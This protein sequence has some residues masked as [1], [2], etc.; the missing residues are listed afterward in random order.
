MPMSGLEIGNKKMK[1]HFKV[2]KEKKGGYWADCIELEGCRTQ[3]ATLKTLTKN[4]SEALNLY[5]SE[6]PESQHVFARPQKRINGKNIVLVAVDPAVAMANRIRELRL[7]NHLTQM[8][9]KDRLGIKN[10][11]N[12]Q[13]LEDP[14]KANPEWSTLMNIKEQF[15]QFRLDDLMD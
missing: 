10:L 1:Y 9:M 14:Y 8:A 13:R 11:S 15:P 6:P 5:L 7:K 4:M 2:H 3:G 12:Y